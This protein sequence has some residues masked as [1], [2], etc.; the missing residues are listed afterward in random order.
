[1]FFLLFGSSAAGKTVALNAPRS[2]VS[3]LEVHDFDEIGV[4]PG[5]DTA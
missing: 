4:P 1:M 5:A 2:R 3:G